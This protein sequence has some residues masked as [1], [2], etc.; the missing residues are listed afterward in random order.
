MF[1]IDDIID[2]G[3][4]IEKNGEK[5]LRDAQ[6]KVQNPELAS[7]FKWLADEEVEHTTWLST[8]KPVSGED[9]DTGSM[10][11][12]GRS[13][14]RNILGEESFSLKN[15]DFSK[16]DQA[17][18]LISKMIEFENDTVLFYKMIRSVVSDKK[19]IDCIDTIIDQEQQHAQKLQQFL[20]SNT[21]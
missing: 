12:M 10:E 19:T 15:F 13:L 11:A 18:D 20:E 17:D 14:L 3:I 5:I 6:T 7:L 4:Q 2:L 9:T 21:V 16:T 1:T 8:L